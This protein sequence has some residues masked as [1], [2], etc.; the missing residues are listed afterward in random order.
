MCEAWVLSRSSEFRLV[1]KGVRHLY[2]SKAGQ[3]RQFQFV[4]PPSAKD[5]HGFANVMGM[6][7]EGARI[8]ASGTEASYFIPEPSRLPDVPRSVPVGL[9]TAWWK[10]AHGGANDVLL[11][12]LRG[13][14]WALMDVLQLGGFGV[15]GAVGSIEAWPGV[16]L[17]IFVILDARLFKV[18]GEGIVK[19]GFLPCHTD[20]F[21]AH[22]VLAWHRVKNCSKICRQD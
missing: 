7:F 4:P 2:L 10:Y 22:L 15:E 16:K 11:A 3:Q 20:N 14:F 18:E 8:N 9:R 5:F 17:A 6:S 1:R 21:D 13:C 12:S 19:E